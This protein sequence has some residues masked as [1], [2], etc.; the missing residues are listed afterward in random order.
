MV[1]MV[2]GL[3]NI[4]F[5]P[6][7]TAVAIMN[8]GPGITQYFRNVYNGNVDMWKDAAEFMNAYAENV[9]MQQA[10]K[11]D[12]NYQELQTDEAKIAVKQLGHA[13]MGGMATTEILTVFV[14]W[15]KISKVAK[16]G[17]VA[18]AAS[19][20]EKVVESANV[21]NKASKAVK[22]EET[23]TKAG[24]WPNAFEFGAKAELGASR[25]A[26]VAAVANRISHLDRLKPLLEPAKV[27][28]LQGNRALNSRLHKVLFWLNQAEKDG[29]NVPETLTRAMKM[30]NADRR[31]A[32]TLLDPAIDRAQILKTYDTAKAMKIFDEDANLDLMRHGKAPWVNTPWGRQQIWVEHEIPVSWENKLGNCWGNLSYETQKYNAMRGDKITERS[33]QKL[34]EYRNAGLLKQD[35]IDEIIRVAVAP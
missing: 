20:A 10:A 30:A 4:V 35:R 18:E 9:Y 33:M 23:L 7:D 22:T 13:K 19:K 25:M 27:A 5:H 34:L 11:F 2:K 29:R 28:T 26:K 32:G 3:A 15:L 16:A 14:G 17:E 24:K 1:D 12:L 31:Y 8:S 21:A 6:V